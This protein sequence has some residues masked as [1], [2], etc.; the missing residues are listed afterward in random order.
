MKEKKIIVR[1]LLTCM[2]DGLWFSGELSMWNILCASYL[3]LRADIHED[4]DVMESFILHTEQYFEDILKPL[5]MKGIPLSDYP[6]LV[7]SYLKIHEFCPGTSEVDMCNEMKDELDFWDRFP[8]VIADK[9]DKITK[10][11]A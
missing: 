1:H 2:Q 5:G 7:E 6:E 3:L 11:S 10:K 9:W 4:Y 8:E